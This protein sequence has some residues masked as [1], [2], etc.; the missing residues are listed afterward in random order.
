M[1]EYKNLKGLLGKDG[2]TYVRDT[3]GSNRYTL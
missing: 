3:S 2:K 1:S